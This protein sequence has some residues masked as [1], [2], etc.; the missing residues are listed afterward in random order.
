MSI[1]RGVTHR[2]GTCTVGSTKSDANRTVVIPPHIRAD[3]TAHLDTW[4]GPESDALLFAP[5][6]GGCHLNDKSFAG[7]YLKPAL[8]SI[9]EGIG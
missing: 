4:T 8:K 7:S 5:V 3:V 2:S 6:R 1:T 9:G